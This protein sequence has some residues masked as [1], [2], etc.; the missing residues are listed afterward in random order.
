[1]QNFHFQVHGDFGRWFGGLHSNQFHF[2]HLNC[3][4]CMWIMEQQ[5]LS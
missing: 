1:M 5:L 4:R 3:E 2:I